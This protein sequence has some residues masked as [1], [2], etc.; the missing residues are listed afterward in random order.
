PHGP[1]SLKMG[2][3]GI[4]CTACHRN[5]PSAS[6]KHIMTPLTAPLTAGSRGLPLLVPKNTLPSATIG[7]PYALL[8]SSAAHLILRNLPSSALQSIGRFFAAG[9]AMLRCGVPP[10]M[11]QSPEGGC[12]GSA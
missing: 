2:S 7:P 11:G 4:S 8:P 9:L 12:L 3:A 6:L 1:A 10:N 5:L